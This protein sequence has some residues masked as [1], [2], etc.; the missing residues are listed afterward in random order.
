MYETCIKSLFT[1]VNNPKWAQNK[2]LLL[3]LISILVLQKQTRYRKTSFPLF[4]SSVDY[5][6]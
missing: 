4:S 5:G 2:T 6:F 3:M 1:Q